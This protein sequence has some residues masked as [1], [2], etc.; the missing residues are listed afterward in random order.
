MDSVCFAGKQLTPTRLM[1][2]LGTSAAWSSLASKSSVLD[3]GDGSGLLDSHD[4]KLP[5]LSDKLQ[6]AHIL[7]LHDEQPL[8][9]VTVDEKFSDH[10]Q[11]AAEASVTQGCNLTQTVLNGTVVYH[12]LFFS[13]F[14]ILQLDMLYI[15]FC[16]C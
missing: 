2:C 8:G 7:Q 9:S 4:L 11:Q 16:C 1:L 10:S 6:R 13:I 14:P 5:L 15:I 12:A 3:D